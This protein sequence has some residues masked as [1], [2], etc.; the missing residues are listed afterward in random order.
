[1]RLQEAPEL[2]SFGDDSL[3]FGESSNDDGERYIPPKKDAS[4]VF[5]DFKL[6][7]FTR[8]FSG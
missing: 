7:N 2:G 3:G 1:M 4:G 5:V 8:T 6:R